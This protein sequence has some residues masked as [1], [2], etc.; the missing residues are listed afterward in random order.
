MVPK[1]SVIMPSFNVAGYIRTCMESVLGQ[2]LSDIEVIAVDAGS[3]DGTWEILEEVE[4]KDSRLRV[5]KSERKSYGY[6]VNQGISLAVGEFVAVAETDDK[7]APDAY[8][9]LYRVAQET[10]ADY[11]KG[12]A[13][14]FMET[15]VGEDIRYEMR[16]YPKD[17]YEANEGRITVIPKERPEL[18]LLDYY[19]WNGIYKREFAKRIRLNESAGAAYQ[20]IGFMIQVHSNARLAV[21][22]DK[23]V[24]YYRKDNV[25][26]SC[27]NR[28]AF[29]YLAE[30]Y[31]YVNQFL[32]KRGTKWQSA[33]LCKM[34]RQMNARFQIMG[35]SGEFWQE[36]WGDI[37]FLAKQIKIAV[38]QGL[39]ARHMLDEGEW[40]DMECLLEDPKQLFGRY[41]KTFRE[42]KEPLQKILNIVDIQEAVIFGCGK[43]GR[44]CHILLENRRRGAVLAYCDNNETIWETRVQGIPVLDPEKAV[45]KYPKAH[46]ILASK[47]NAR[48]LK[49]QLKQMGIGDRS[50]S[51]YTA[52]LDMQMMN[53]K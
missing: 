1:I 3:T 51:E 20:D 30:E 7:I 50:I 17:Q 5:I 12:V 47:Y 9:I 28:K 40:D 42:R 6:Q 18:V 35:Q 8:E 39:I 31:H 33:C 4:K 22:L 49:C 46:Y 16:I 23:V 43:W 44:F 37:L 2:N 11:V 24:Y 26:S 15:P 29:R 27:Y 14:V 21:Y 53:I 32:E 48:E 34:F 25:N 52:G 19:L 45:Q 38:D 41:E 10:G 13:E 36:A